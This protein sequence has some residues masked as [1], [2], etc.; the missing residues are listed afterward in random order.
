MGKITRKEFLKLLNRVLAVTGLAVVFGP[1]IAYFFPAKLEETPSEPV[2]AGTLDD[3]PEGES[4]MV[5]FGR[6]PALLI[7]TPQG[8]RAYSAVCTHFACLVK[9]DPDAGEIMCPCHDAGFDVYT[10]EVLHGPPPRGLDVIAVE[11][12]DGQIYV[13]GAG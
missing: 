2:P 6:Y 3:L 11:V 5:R 4:K 10:G 9:W 13:G 7:N 12:V 1:I 8:L